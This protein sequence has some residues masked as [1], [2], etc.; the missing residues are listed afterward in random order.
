MFT[1]NNLSG[2]SFERLVR[3]LAYEVLGASACVFS[4]GPDA[5]RDMTVEGKIDAYKANGWDGYLVLQSKYRAPGSSAQKMTDA[6]WLMAQL[7]SEKE[8]FLDPENGRRV[9]DYYLL[10]TNAALSGADGRSSIKGKGR[11][12]GHTLV[13][14]E[15]ETWKRDLGIKDFDIW[16]HDKI[17]DLLA[18]NVA[19]RQTFA[20]WVTPGDVLEQVMQWMYG[21]TPD[22][23]VNMRRS[24]MTSLR[25]KEYAELKDA[26][27]VADQ[28][29]RTGQV[30]VDVPFE[31]SGR[32][33]GDFAQKSNVVA[34]LVARSRNKFDADI[35]LGQSSNRD[36]GTNKIVVLGGP[37]QGKSTISTYLAQIFRSTILM[38]D[39][40]AMRDE[41][42]RY[43]A[44]EVVRRATEENISDRVPKRYPAFVSLP[45]YADQISAARAAQKRLPS[46]LQHIADEISETADSDISKDDL[47]KWLSGYPWIIILD[48]LDEVPPSGERTA[49]IDSI[50]TLSSEV[51]QL[52]GDVLFLLTTRPQGYNNDLNPETWEHWELSDL[53]IE[54]A[55][56]YT[57]A[58]AAAKYPDDRPRRDRI[59]R[60]LAAASVAPAT[61]RLLVTPLQATILFLI[62]DTGG[63][64]PTARWS[65]FNEYFEVLKRREKAK[66]GKIGEAID[67]NWSHLGL[68]HQAIGLI[69][70]TRSEIEGGAGS[71]LSSSD[72]EKILHAYFIDLGFS[73]ANLKSRINDV[74]ELSLQ[75][76]VLLT[77][78]NEGFI[79]FDVRS[80]QEFMAAAALTTGDTDRVEGRLEALAGIAHWRHVWLIA[81]SRCFAEDAY[82]YRRLSVVGIPR[83]LEVGDLDRAVENGARLA[84]QLFRDG[85]GLEHPTARQILAKHAIEGLKFG[86]TFLIEGVSELWED[87]AQVVVLEGVIGA[88]RSGDHIAALGAWALV[89]KLNDPVLT[90]AALDFWP[91]D[92][93]EALKV[94]AAIGRPPKAEDLIEVVRTSILD[95]NAADVMR[96]LIG[97][98]D[99][100][101]YIWGEFLSGV[102][103]PKTLRD[104]GWALLPQ[105]G[106][107]FVS[108][109]EALV[110][111]GII[112]ALSQNRCWSKNAWPVIEAIG[113]FERAASAHS[114]GLTLEALSDH[115]CHEEA[116]GMGLRSCWPLA[117]IVSFAR[118]N[119]ELKALAIKAANGEF[120]D[121]ADWRSAEER[122]AEDGI[123]AS[124]LRE[125]DLNYPFSAK[126]AVNGVPIFGGLGVSME[127]ENAF[128]FFP[129]ALQVFEGI[130]NP[131]LRNQLSWI[132]SFAA[133]GLPFN[134]ISDLNLAKKLLNCALENEKTLYLELVQVFSRRCW[135]DDE[136]C[137]LMAK[138]AQR[139]IYF[140]DDRP[141]INLANIFSAI[142]RSQE[143]GLYPLAL[144]VALNQG[145]TGARLAEILPA[146]IELSSETPVPVRCSI[147]ALQALS[148][149]ETVA[150]ATLAELFSTWHNQERGK[151]E[152]ILELFLESQALIPE[153]SAEVCGTI[154]DTLNRSDRSMEVLL[155]SLK[156]ALDR[157]RSGLAERSVWVDKMVL[158]PHIYDAVRW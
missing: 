143:I 130:D 27:S 1:L 35:K 128:D 121:Y 67:R 127:V 90:R 3:A 149:S 111:P 95:M 144:I 146:N 83:A 23:G 133:V 85:I 117:S 63:T 155:I 87:E 2:Q 123:S 151:V 36:L 104:K 41:I 47:R 65:L 72:L 147:L 126:I 94:L 138:V 31:M 56:T 37:G 61:S 125:V 76:L 16:P 44:P 98:D 119:G 140:G 71:Q 154:R 89:W 53:P 29:V 73:G 13:A 54:R 74:V 135:L 116:V 78:K 114:L 38:S 17:V 108:V 24:L 101:S 12:G 49:V 7:A 64:A 134:S 33:R 26:G 113:K 4:A 99:E 91:S 129:P 88:L 96:K 22:F 5:G 60:S 153:Y 68:I 139:E 82:E 77:A 150:A 43:V 158:P 148:A 50:N 18:N 51:T 97:N 157:R 34:E 142:K 15:L 75:R 20:A 84:L 86:A 100:A 30:F 70:Q 118:D 109:K 25:R 58:L 115:S 102:P 6:Q 62:V 107:D 156:S 46:L 93:S 81:A 14:E 55:L 28:I 132:I 136:F 137:K 79:Q 141:R 69:L 103:L 57:A 52:G 66:P 152:G 11:I 110:H 112:S 59:G 122:W 131:K 19:V 105:G 8:A 21:A 48:G 145:Y 120:G 45:L 106:N 32:N 92:P 10:V 42:I 39:P 124:D 9:P 80:L 40:V